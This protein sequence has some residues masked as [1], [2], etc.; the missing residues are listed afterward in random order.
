MEIS[1]LLF[2]QKVLE[3]CVTMDHLQ[4]FDDW[5]SS[6]NKQ[7]RFSADEACFLIKAIRNKEEKIR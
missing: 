2:M 3:S 6:L 7:G 1:D 5:A 4:S